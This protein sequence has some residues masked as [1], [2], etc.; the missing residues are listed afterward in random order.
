MVGR[1]SARVFEDCMIAKTFYGM[2]D[3]TCAQTQ[4]FVP[5]RAAL[6]CLSGLLCSVTY[7]RSSP[8][9][10]GVLS[11]L[12]WHQSGCHSQRLRGL[13]PGLLHADWQPVA[14][15]KGIRARLGTYASVMAV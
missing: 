3:H 10:L 5:S 4:H 12:A 9:W 6:L 1:R 13:P 2:H 8:A 14:T 15:H 11:A 7:A